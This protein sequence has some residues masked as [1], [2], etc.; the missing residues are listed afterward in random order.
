MNLLLS[1]VIIR[2]LLKLPEM[3]Y[4][5][6]YRSYDTIR[7]FPVWREQLLFFFTMVTAAERSVLLLVNV[8]S[9]LI[10]V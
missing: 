3:I 6:K 9:T 8:T 2:I 5:D 10:I 7:I 1:S 4:P